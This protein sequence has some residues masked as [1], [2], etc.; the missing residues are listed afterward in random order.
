MTRQLKVCT[1]T[2]D[3][4]GRGLGVSGYGEVLHSNCTRILKSGGDRAK[5]SKRTQSSSLRGLGFCATGHR[6][7][8]TDTSEAA[9]VM[10]GS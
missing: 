5:H 3:A 10:T 2:Y 1:V 9:V 4:R 7:G 6:H 8:P